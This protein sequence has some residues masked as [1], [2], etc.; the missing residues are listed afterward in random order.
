MR[1]IRFLICLCSL[2]LLLFLPASGNEGI[3]SHF[4]NGN[5]IHKVVSGPE[6]MWCAT[7]GGL[8][9]WNKRDGSYVHFTK[10]D[11]LLSNNLATLAI[12]HT[13][14]L[15]I[16]Y[17]DVKGAVTR[18]DGASWSIIDGSTG[19][20]P[21]TQILSM[22]SDSAGRMWFGTDGGGIVYYEDDIWGKEDSIKG[23]D[24]INE[25]TFDADGVMWFA[26]RFGVLS[27]D[28]I[29]WSRNTTNS[30]LKSD[31]ITSITTDDRDV[32]W[33]GTSNGIARFDGDTWIPYTQSD[34]LIDNR[35]NCL[36]QGTGGVL[37]IGTKGGASKFDGLNWL[38]FTEEDG[39]INNNVTGITVDGNGRIWLAHDT[40]Y[41][42]VSVFNGNQWEWYTTWNSG[43]VSNQV[44]AL[45]SDKDGN[46]W[47]GTDKGVSRFDG[48]TWK[49]YSTKDG[50]AVKNVSGLYIDNRNNLWV[51]YEQSK[52]AGIT[53]FDGNVWKTYTTQD[54]LLH[55]SV[56]SIAQ[57]KNEGM[58]FDTSEGLS[59]FDGVNWVNYPNNQWLLSPHIYDIA[60]DSEGFVWFGTKNGLTRF[61]GSEW[62]TFTSEGVL[63][64]DNFVDVETSDNGIIWCVTENGDLV[65]FDGS[66]FI[67]HPIEQTWESYRSTV[68]GIA[69]DKEGIIWTNT[70]VLNED[71]H[72]DATQV[73]TFDGVVWNECSIDIFRDGPNTGLI[74]DIIAD[75]N[76]TIWFGTQH[77]LYQYD[78]TVLLNYTMNAPFANDITTITIDKNNRKLFGTS[79][80]VFSFDNVSFT[81]I[82][83]TPVFS[84]AVDHNNVQWFVTP[85]GVEVN[86]S[87]TWKRFT[88][89]NGLI[90]NSARVIGVDK[91]NIKWV[92][93]S[94]GVQSYDGITWKLH[95]N[96]DGRYSDFVRVFA[97]DENNVKWFGNGLWAELWSYD[98]TNWKHYTKDDGSILRR[99]YAIA[100]DK[101]NVK[102]IGTHYELARYDGISM[103]IYT[104]ADGL[105]S[106]HVTALATDNNNIVWVGTNEGV[107][108]FDG[109]SWITY[110][111]ENGLLSNSITSIAVDY[112]N[113]KWFGTSEG[114]SSFDDR[115]LSDSRS[116]IK[117]ITIRGNYPNP[118]NTSTTVEFN[119]SS[120]VPVNFT[121]YNV[122]GQSVR[123][124]SM[125]KLPA[126]SHQVSWDGL[127]QY[128]KPVSSGVYLYRIETGEHHKSGR[129][130]FLK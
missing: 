49:T 105:A 108:R 51:A 99:I 82:T 115:S 109:E 15:W 68:T 31:I 32:K 85:S 1:I 122:M 96:G 76:N 4:V 33:I 20:L 45:A 100:V 128:G 35:V 113:V 118:F 13:G 42:G 107:S 62:L 81:A 111:E 64:A 10:F 102:W 119:L 41:N 53:K 40:V 83:D 30:N 97:V 47:L 72:I 126:G 19:K 11:G 61:D 116:T 25:I 127:D 93:T 110:T 2:T 58:V 88:L 23:I 57:V 98:G 12:D 26:T 78:G 55:N 77:G 24:Q 29:N 38:S 56:T 66:K 112:N 130:M 70:P 74:T 69:V 75:E 89:E 91:N 5:D 7:S 103:T 101:N 63:N 87:S 50:L 106:N 73:W 86:D 114:I 22:F 95:A 52:N 80:G 59:L 36:A 44:D 117:P 67:K 104:E 37:W 18:Y 28:G 92:G 39:L 46:V 90:S 27:F 71:G 125:G 60:E 129:M 17:D 14:A 79:R 94:L 21:D 3:W 16:S 65:S 34:G 48:V 8:V 84:I 120:W 9:G 124:L 121:V 54:G 123:E 43:L 6:Y